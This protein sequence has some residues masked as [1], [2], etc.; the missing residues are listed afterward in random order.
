MDARAQI[1]VVRLAG[2]RDHP[3]EVVRVRRQAVTYSVCEV[4]VG[5]PHHV[6]PYTLAHVYH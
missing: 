3:N 1:D 4:G 2:T 5:R 6:Q